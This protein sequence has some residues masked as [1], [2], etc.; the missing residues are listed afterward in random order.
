MNKFIK[1]IKKQI[2]TAISALPVEWKLSPSLWI[3]NKR[4]TCCPLGATII[5]HHGTNVDPLEMINFMKKI[6]LT[7]DQSYAFADGFDGGYLGS[8]EI[9]FWELGKSYRIRYVKNAK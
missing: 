6:G 8:G 3:N 5:Y 4:K 7:E 2:D 9:D 1:K